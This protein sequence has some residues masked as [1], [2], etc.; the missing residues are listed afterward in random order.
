MKPQ[1]LLFAI[2]LSAFFI[3]LLKVFLESVWDK[4]KCA[5]I[6]NGVC[7]KNFA[8]STGG[9]RVVMRHIK[10]EY[11]YQGE[12][13]TGY[14][15]DDNIVKNG[16]KRFV[17]GESYPLYINPNK[18]QSFRCGTKVYYLREI[19]SILLFAFMSLVSVCGIIACVESF[20]VS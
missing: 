10:F 3:Y 1:Y 15:L 13:Y 5:V 17:V 20:F 11:S 18:P 6:I 4:K 14:A 2:P 12:L 8:G 16:G 19:F 7:M 9:S